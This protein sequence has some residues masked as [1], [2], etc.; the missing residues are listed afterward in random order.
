ML[1]E[2]YCE[3]FGEEKRIS[4]YQ[5]LNIIQGIGDSSD[6]SG[7]NS[8]GK[9][10]MLKIID[11]AFG[12]R[13]YAQSNDDVLRHVGSHDI[14]FTH[15]FNGNSFYFRR[16]AEKEN[17][18][19]RCSDS[20]YIPHSE[21]SSQDFCKWLVD[22]YDLQDLDLSFRQIVSLYSRIWDKPNKDVNR[23]LYNHS[24]QPVRNAITV[25]IK[26]FGKYAS[27]QELNEHD[28]YLQKRQQA[29]SKAVSYN[30]LKLPSK[31]EKEKIVSELLEI[32][33]TILTLRKN[34]S[35]CCVENATI[36][37]D[38]VN[39]LYEKRADLLTQEGRVKRDL[40]RCQGNMRK[41]SPLKEATFS[42]LIEF[43]PEVNVQ[44]ISEVQSFHDNLR[45]VLLEE[46]QQEEAL[47][48]QRL[49]ELTTSIQSNE[50][51]IEEQ[52]ALPTQTDE[53]VSQMLALV[54]RKEQ[55][56][57][58]VD[59]FDDKAADIA[60]KADNTKKLAQLLSQINAD[61]QEQINAKISEY[62][63]Q[64]ASSNSKSPS[65][66]LYGKEYEYGVEDNTGTGKAYTDLLLFDLAILALTRLP[67]IIHDSFL[68][69]NI[70]DFTKLSLLRLYSQFPEK[71]LFI[72]LDQYYGFNDDEINQ[73]LFAST[74][75][76]L[77]G[78]KTLFGKDWRIT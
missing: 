75:L 7:A 54:K 28:E 74:R 66:R 72:S 53:A 67:I 32:D 23:P 56:Q 10:N 11:Y 71:Q 31:A 68:F 60:Q 64:I 9:T 19:F 27:I 52:T 20:N 78:N 8:I 3:A 69:N 57:A 38:Q 59:L 48:L 73:I 18:V 17:V 30:L 55:L 65:L 12:G 5:G 29:I 13:Y 42:S 16:N 77:S 33:D 47:L 34:I 43:F 14:C 24:S 35:F 4:F 49:E 37:S 2:I 63:T 21:M 51:A 40:H 22:Q 1:T 36:L 46:L 39:S 50:R 58:Q 62:S 70:D 45:A 76:I 61:I 15:T 26:L 6:S 25:L 44:R 41:L